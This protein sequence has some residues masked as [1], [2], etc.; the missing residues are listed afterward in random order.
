MEILTQCASVTTYDWF[1]HHQIKSFPGWFE[2][3]FLLL[4]S[5]AMKWINQRR[6]IVTSQ[7]VQ[8]HIPLLGACCIEWKC[9]LAVSPES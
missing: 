9:V 6:L 7:L 5:D 2:D 3:T 8:L 4:S 1:F